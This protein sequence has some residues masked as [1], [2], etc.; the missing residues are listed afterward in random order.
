MRKKIFLII[1]PVVLVLALLAGAIT[2]P[3][4]KS[5]ITPYYSGEAVNFNG[6][7]YIGTTNTGFFELFKLIDNRITRVGTIF[8]KDPA[9]SYFLDTELSKENGRLYIYLVNGTYIYKYRMNYNM[10]LELVKRAEDNSGEYIFGISKFGNNIITT[11]KKGIKVWNSD[12]VITNSFKDEVNF[13]D[14]LA[15]S[16]NGNYFFNIY[17]EYFAIIESFY[18]NIIN[19]VDLS[20]NDFHARRPYFDNIEG[21]VYLVDDSRLQKYYLD[22]GIVAEFN[23]ISD[24]GYDVD[25]LDGAGYV[26]FSDGIGI[27]KN[28]KN[29]LKPEDWVFTTDIGPGNGWAMGLRA[30]EYGSG[31]AVIVFNGSSILVFDDNFNL[32]DL[33]EAREINDYNDGFNYEPLYLNLN[34]N[35]GFP[36][37]YV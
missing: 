37:S 16:D 36:G 12:L 18:R 11:D 5:Q 15:F 33:Y 19:G 29:D 13:P 25:G 30:V 14:N 7:V 26:Y 28:H 22:T 35:W 1:L 34:K 21:A 24:L 4:A 20:T 10:T 8:S 23:H 2:A 6:E 3:K 17:F 31:E 9:N 32:I 27:V